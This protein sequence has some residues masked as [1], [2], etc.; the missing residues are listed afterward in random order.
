MNFHGAEWSGVQTIGQIDEYDATCERERERE[1]SLFSTV[2]ELRYNCIKT[3]VHWY[4][5][6]TN[7]QIYQHKELSQYFSFSENLHLVIFAYSELQNF[8]FFLC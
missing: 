3:R 2:M 8:S 6:Q 4:K 7:K 1:R 5:R